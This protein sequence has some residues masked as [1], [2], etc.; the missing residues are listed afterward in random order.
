MSTID[1]VLIDSNSRL[2]VI[3]SWKGEVDKTTKDLRGQIQNAASK[4]ELKAVSEKLEKVS[5]ELSDVLT[6]LSTTSQP[7]KPEPGKPEPSKPDP[8]VSK[9]LEEVGTLLVFRLG[10]YLTK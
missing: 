4:E 9:Q 1:K 3:E 6:R 7:A 10:L 8:A 2:T 5:K